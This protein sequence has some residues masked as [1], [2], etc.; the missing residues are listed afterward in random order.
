MPASQGHSRA[1]L[2]GLAT[3]ALSSAL[4]MWPVPGAHRRGHVGGEHGGACVWRSE[5]NLEEFIPSLHHVHPGNRT[6]VLILGGKPHQA[7]EGMVVQ[8]E[9]QAA[10]ADLEASLLP[11]AWPHCRAHRTLTI[12]VAIR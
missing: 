10:K 11:G 7:K 4:C 2:P 8:W 12:K 1:H 3:A 6:Q 5:D 9:T